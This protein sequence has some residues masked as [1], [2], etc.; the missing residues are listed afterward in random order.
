M[1]ALID[2][3]CRLDVI[4]PGDVAAGLVVRDVSPRHRVYLVS[5]AAS[6]AVKM[7]AAPTRGH[8]ILQER[9]VLEW[10][11]PRIPGLAPTVLAWDA[12]RELL[13]LELLAGETL[14]QH[15][16]RVGHLSDNVARCL[17]ERLAELHGLTAR[18]PYTADVPAVLRFHRPVPSELG[19]WTHAQIALTKLVQRSSAACAGLDTAAAGWRPST[20]IHGDIRWENVMVSA[21]P[22]V[23]TLRV[24]DWESAGWG[25][26]CWDVAAAIACT[27]RDG[28]ARAANAGDSVSELTLAADLVVEQARAAVAALWTAWEAPVGSHGRSDARMREHTMRLV[29]ARLLQFANEIAIDSTQLGRPALLIAR[30]GMDCLERPRAA[31]AVLLPSGPDDWEA[32]W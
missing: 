16:G 15:V 22:G 2:H 29:G 31:D 28:L 24:I 32:A 10:L 13:V 1:F 3:L 6:A 7:P 8:L 30:V 17:G 4:D 5:G 19:Y 27:V 9:D 20:T 26:P 21:A 11:G 14:S 18:P 23:A 12:Q 25:D